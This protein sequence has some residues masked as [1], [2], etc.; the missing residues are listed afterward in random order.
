[1]GVRT[2]RQ[3][4]DL[5]GGDPEF[6]EPS[7]ELV[8]ELL[9]AEMRDGFREVDGCVVP[10]SFQ[11]SSIWSDARPRTNNLDDETGFECSLSKVHLEDFVDSSISLAELARIGCAYAMH[12]R[13][14]LLDSPVS[15][16]FR[17][18]VAVQGPDAELRIGN[19]CSVRFHRIRQGQSWLDDDI[20]SY[21]EDALLV[22]EFEK[23]AVRDN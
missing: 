11:D 2:N 22:F 23:P 5:L 16:Q 8:P 21:K 17:I 12:L 4:L 6:H 19:V 15:G 3:I 18:I 13:Q 10:Y 14:A 20:E 1:M 9:V 7:V